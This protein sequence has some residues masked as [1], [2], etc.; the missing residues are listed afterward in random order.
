[1][2]KSEIKKEYRHKRRQKLI[3][4][5]GGKCLYNNCNSTESLEFAH[6]SQTKLHG[7]GRGQDERL[8]DITDNPTSY[9]LFCKKHHREFDNNGKKNNQSIQV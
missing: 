6:L 8:K 1:M 4:Q 9:T 3:Q 2:N 7:A 5:F